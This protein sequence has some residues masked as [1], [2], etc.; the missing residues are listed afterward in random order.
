MRGRRLTWTIGG[1]GLIGSGVAGILLSATL[2]SSL[3]DTLAFLVDLL[4]AAAVLVFAIGSSA[5]DSITARRPL[6]TITL[7]LVA[8]SPLAVRVIGLFQDPMNPTPLIPWEV[9][10]FMPLALSLVAVVQIARAGVVP[11][12]WRWTPAIALGVQVASVAI[13]QLLMMDQASAMQTIGLASAL[14]MLGFLA[15]TVG[16]GI[17]ALVAAAAERPASVP[18]L[19]SPNASPDR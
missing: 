4:W 5:H 12:R 10:T 3:T 1:I 13:G 6:G 18:V 2:G 11:R 19:S 17:I 7:A 16:L 8:V 9:T 15:G 14:G